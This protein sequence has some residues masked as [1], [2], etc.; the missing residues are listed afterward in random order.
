[1][2]IEFLSKFATLASSGQVQWT[3]D[4]VCAA[5]VKYCENPSCKPVANTLTVLAEKE[6]LLEG[7]FFDLGEHVLTE[8]GPQGNSTD[9][10]Q[11]N[12][13]SADST[14]SIGAVNSASNVAAFGSTVLLGSFAFML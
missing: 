4:E 6:G 11:G 9:G 5:V 3:A 1:L 7:L 14:G 8:L 12:S 13:G 2:D 10:Q